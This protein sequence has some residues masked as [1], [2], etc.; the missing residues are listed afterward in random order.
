MVLV[1]SRTELTKLRHIRLL[2]VS[3]LLNDPI[4]QN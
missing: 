2:T 1:G 4:P 3:D